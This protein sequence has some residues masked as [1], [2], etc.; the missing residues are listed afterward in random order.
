MKEFTRYDRRTFMGYFASVGLGSTVLPGVLW[1]KAAAGAEITTA[2]IAS[3]E[4]MA[5]LQFTDDQRKVMLEGIKNTEQRLEALHKIPLNNSVVP[6]IVFN[7]RPQGPPEV[8]RKRGQI[9]KRSAARVSRPANLEDL[10]FQPVTVL[11][12]LIRR[13]VITPSELTKMYIARI[14]KFDPQIMAVVTLLEDRALD[15]AKKADAEIARGNYRGPL[16]GIPWGAKDLLAV[17][18]YKTTWGAGPYR[19]QVI[20]D[21]ATVVKRLDEAGAILLAKLTLGELAQGDIWFGGMTKNPW[22]L[23]Q[24]SSG[25]SAGPAAATAA[26]M[27][28]FGVG[29]ETLGSISS[30]S[31]RVGTTGLRPT[32]GRVPRTGAM[33]LSWTMD[34]LGA[35]CRS[36]EDCALVLDA[37]YG[38]D[39]KDPAAIEAPFH[40]D[41][42]IDVRKLR[43]GYVKTAF[44]LPRLDPKDE[45][46]TMH[47]T[48]QF[49]DAALNVLGKL[50]VKLLPVDLPDVPYDPMRIILNAEAAAAFDDLTR[51]GRDA[52]LVQ[53]TPFDWANT[54]RVARFI[55]AVDYIN[56]NRV[57]T[58][59]IQKWDEMFR[60][61][62]VIV[63]PTTAANLPQLVATNLTGHPALILPNGFRDDGTPVSLTFLGGLFEEAKLLAVADAYQRAT[64][65][66]LKHPTLSVRPA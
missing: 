44:D 33:A 37:I 45:K 55:P 66:H 39:G 63:T 21:D 3:A 54:F 31:T 9:Q 6:A 18:N 20:D 61:F 53:Q 12:D 47:A 25:S 46:R 56:A 5:G 16:H 30:P 60:N 36:A 29:S 58:I 48:K 57:R 50:G 64:S 51:S 24:G 32:F 2:T 49:D 34:K 27:I 41:P 35:L 7:P 62:D 8:P 19:D 22:K 13:R 14:R 26:G 15:Q 4:E 10:A 28:A 52:L 65:F 40:W 42:T 17:R 38:P 23:D 1:A 43:I 59:A 11:S